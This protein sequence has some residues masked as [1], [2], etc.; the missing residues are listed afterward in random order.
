M[1]RK[2]R[3]RQVNSKQVENWIIGVHAGERERVPSCPIRSAS[4]PWS[5]SRPGEGIFGDSRMSSPSKSYTKSHFH[6]SQSG[7]RSF[8]VMLYVV[9]RC[10][11]SALNSP[12]ISPP[13][14]CAS[15]VATETE[16]SGCAPPKSSSYGLCRQEPSMYSASEKMSEE[17]WPSI[18]RVLIPSKTQSSALSTPIPSPDR[19]P[20]LVSQK[21]LPFF[22][23]RLATKSLKEP[24]HAS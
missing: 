4:D 22:I 20:L 8:R 1:F 23:W 2:D 6:R 14:D 24:R 3:P 5:Y 17:L 16:R 9:T 18:R 19:E 7:R 12:F 15:S 13:N 10:R 21:R 11:R